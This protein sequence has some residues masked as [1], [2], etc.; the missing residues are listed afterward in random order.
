MQNKSIKINWLNTIFLIATPVIG[1]IGTVLLCYFDMVKWQTW[2]FFGVYVFLT[3]LA[4]TAGYHRLFAHKSYQ[5]HPVITFIMAMLGAA[6]FEG[7]VL[8]WGTDHRNHHRFVDTE[9]D[10]YNINQGFWYAHV[11]WLIH[12]DTSKRDFSNVDDLASSAILRFQH[13]YFKECAIFMGL[14][15]PMLIGALWGN[16]LAGFIIAGTLRIVFNHHSTF[17]IN[18]LCHWSGKQTYTREQTARDNWMTALVTMGEGFHNFHHQFPLD[19]R[20]GVRYFHYD[21]TKWLI[22]GLSKLGL[23]NNLRRISDGKILAFRLRVEEEA[24]RNKHQQ[25]TAF[26]SQ[27]MEPLKAHLLSLIDK[28]TQLEIELAALK[29]KKIEHVKGKYQAYRHQLQAYLTTIKMV[30]KELNDSLMSWRRL[31]A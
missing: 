26:I 14:I 24:L 11:G 30:Q 9:K 4:I 27:K 21:P 18:S 8:E 22:Y 7:S 31:S 12:L 28:I 1:I 29:A 25:D 13:K 19:Y 20:N 2:L 10:P 6:C 17:F 23:A 16:A 3:A 15:L 5:A